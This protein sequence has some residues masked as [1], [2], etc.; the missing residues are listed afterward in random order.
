VN[1]L[2]PGGD[3]WEV[4][5]VLGSK[6]Y[7][8]SGVGAYDSNRNVFLRTA[9]TAEWVYDAATN[10]Y[11]KKGLHT[12]MYWDL[13]NPGLA[14]KLIHIH[15]DSLLGDPL[16]LDAK[17]GMDYDPI[18]D[19]YYLWKGVNELWA[20]KP[21]ENF[22]PTGWTVKRLNPGGTGPTLAGAKFTGVY[23]KWNYMPG[24]NAF[25][26]VVHDLTGDVWIY[27]P[28]AAALDLAFADLGMSLTSPMQ[29]FSLA[30]TDSGLADGR[31]AGFNAAL[32][33]PEPATLALL[34]SGLISFAI[35]RANQRRG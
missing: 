19:V 32:S 7:S 8:S 16:P 21:P 23:G 17:F 14:N 35:G 3:Q 26:G 20:L 9:K 13:N 33:V 10:S 27:K 34:G 30:G 6:T 2:E 5:G 12:L 28:D 1:S 11:V 15:P 29:A 22:G 24:L 4:V 18:G 31:L 25:M